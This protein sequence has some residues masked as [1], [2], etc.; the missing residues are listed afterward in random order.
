MPASSQPNDQ[1]RLE[2]T[3]MSFGS[4]L[5]ELRSAIFKCLAVTIIGFLLGLLVAKHVVHFIQ[6]PLREALETYYRDHAE[7]SHL[8]R[9]EEMRRE[10]LPVPENLGAEAKKM[11]AEG[12][13]PLVYL[14][15]PNEL[16]RALEGSTG[17]LSTNHEQTDLASPD[18]PGLPDA[19]PSPM[20]PPASGNDDQREIA[21][22]SR[23]DL[24]QLHVYQPLEQDPRLR[25]VG[26][27]V[28]EG[29]MVYIKA[30][31]VTGVLIT[32]PF[33]FYFIWEFV[34]AGLYRHEKKHIYIYL[35]LSLGLFLAGAALAFF[36]AFDYVLNFLL[37]FYTIMGVEPDMRISDW[38]GFVLML[39]IG[40]GIS[41]QL[42]LAM[43]FLER[44][45]VFTVDLYL[46]KWRMAILVIAVLSMFLTPADPGSMLVMGL[47]LC[48][49]YFGGIALCHFMPQSKPPI[50]EDATGVDT[51]GS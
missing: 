1:A 32:S 43:L 9:L 25:V 45:G 42:P 27:G 3:K 5:E 29:F 13:V 50:P 49:L 44:T 20:P 46:K 34:A 10:G 47:P 14:F 31:L 22:I 24:I 28:Q 19:E 39:P 4:H 33:I 51:S 7:I 12:L 36:V 11:A 35:P 18:D 48:A 8:A 2:G 15:D 41:F 21:K 17:P 23:S 16:R 6:I 38:V 26:L 30:S 37:W 40:F